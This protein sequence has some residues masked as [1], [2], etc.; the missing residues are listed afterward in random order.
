MSAPP[1][2]PEIAKAAAEWLTLSMG[3]EWSE[4]D[5]SRL[6][7]WRNADPEHER[8]WQ[9]IQYMS[10]ALQR[11]HAP[12]AYQTLS[13][14][15]T[16][17][18]RNVLKTLFGFSIVAGGGVLASRTESWQLQ[19]ADYSTATGERKEQKLADGTQIALN[20]RSAVD[21]H[22]TESERILHLRAGE[23]MV[24]TGHRPGEQ[25]PFRVCTAHGNIY[26]MGTRFNIKYSANS[27]S[28]TVLEGAVNIV[29]RQGHARL[30]HAGEHT[31][32]SPNQ[33]QATSQTPAQADAWQKGLLF[34]NNMRLADLVEELA[35]YRTGF[36]GCDDSVAGLRI[37][38]VFPL[39]NTTQAL[40]ALSNSLPVRLVFHTRYWVRIM[41]NPK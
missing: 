1:F 13:A 39:T 12:A 31:S 27:T 28:V 34:A 29:T 4:N 36:I 6:R 25:R 32:F 11:L 2:S 15:H 21:V 9:H 19:M 24:T 35:R 14:L 20:T 40:A 41:A 5:L 38:G 17:S 18:R 7:Q 33:I 22:F 10:N 8:A 30:I 23:I 3:A 16:P 37:S 26:P